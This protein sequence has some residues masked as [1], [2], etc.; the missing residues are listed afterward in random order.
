MPGAI[1]IRLYRDISDFEPGRETRDQLPGLMVDNPL[2]SLE[3]GRFLPGSGLAQNAWSFTKTSHP[4]SSSSSLR[5]R[6]KIAIL[7]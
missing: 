2:Q 3:T 7:E 6:S 1:G 5:S 4:S